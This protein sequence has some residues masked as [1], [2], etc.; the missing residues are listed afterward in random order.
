MGLGPLGTG[1]VAAGPCSGWHLEGSS[2]G[3]SGSGPLAAR[4]RQGSL[5]CCKPGSGAC[6]PSS[7]HVCLGPPGAAL[8]ATPLTPPAFVLSK[9]PTTFL[10]VSG[11]TGAGLHHAAWDH[12]PQHWGLL[13]APSHGLKP[14][15]RPCPKCI[16]VGRHGLLFRALGPAPGQT[17]SLRP[18]QTALGDQTPAA[19]GSKAS[20]PDPPAPPWQ[21]SFEQ[22]PVSI[23]V[24]P[25]P[26]PLLGANLAHALSI[27]GWGWG[28]PGYVPMSCPSTWGH[29]AGL[30]AG[31][32]R[33]G[34]LA[35]PWLHAPLGGLCLGQPL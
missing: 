24:V 6:E 25:G 21:G 16:H 34:E 15:V 28:F 12:G 22:A 5:P 18:G 1:P 26:L 7:P 9:H 19:A 8:Q 23:G 3:L 17:A 20:S 4:E 2:A 32:T 29:Q 27:L 10:D 35:R 33:A 30:W 14:G 11:E 31:P 13:P